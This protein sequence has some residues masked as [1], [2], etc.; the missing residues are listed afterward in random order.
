MD[1]QFRLIQQELGVKLQTGSYTWNNDGSTCKFAVHGS[2]T[3]PDPNLKQRNDEE[4]KFKFLANARKYGFDPSD[5]GRKVRV[6]YSGVGT[7][8]TAGRVLKL[9][10]IHPNNRKYPIICQGDFRIQWDTHTD[11]TDPT[12]TSR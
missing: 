2:L 5:H 1:K 11:H 6:P 4:D 12:Q 9:K 3:S 8:E 10:S 7:A